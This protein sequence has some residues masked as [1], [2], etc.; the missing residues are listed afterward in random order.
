MP[1]CIFCGTSPTTNAHV[2][3]RGWIDEIM[4]RAGAYRH[5]R[6]GRDD[7]PLQLPGDWIKNGV[8]LKVNAV[9]D[10]CN[11]G[12]MDRLDHAAE[13]SFLTHAVLGYQVKLSRMSEKETLARWC[14]L[15]ATLIDQTLRPP[16]IPKRVHET[17]YREETPEDMQAWVFRTEPPDG[18]DILWGGPRH[19]T[20]SAQMR[21]SGVLH[22]HDV[23]FV[24]FGVL[25]FVAQVVQPTEAAAAEGRLVRRGGDAFTRQIWPAP[26]TPLFW[27]PPETLRWEDAIDL[28]D[29]IMRQGQGESA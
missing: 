2:F 28:P 14:A 21:S 4:P 24:T 13:D 7:S 1:G 23:C 17:L 8:D 20:V 16:T 6:G 5:R 11:S 18:R 26:F 3:R 22:T 25:Q 10:A 27:P 12:W 15:V 29:Q 9:C 19:L